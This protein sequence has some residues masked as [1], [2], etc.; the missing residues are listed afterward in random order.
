[1]FRLELPCRGTLGPYVSRAN[2][3]LNCIV[4]FFETVSL[5][6]WVCV[7]HKYEAHSAGLVVFKVTASFLYSV[8]TTSG[9]LDSLANLG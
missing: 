5:T 9:L 1:M 8:A 6:N 4:W 3:P 2:S 7:E